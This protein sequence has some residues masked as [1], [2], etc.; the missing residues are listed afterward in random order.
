MSDWEK[1]AAERKLNNTIS[2]L[3]RAVE[4]LE[5]VQD[6]AIRAKL[7]EHVLGPIGQALSGAQEAL[8][9][10]SAIRGY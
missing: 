6:M 10:A 4:E 7:D 3:Y 9:R 1:E 5:H 2:S 8:S